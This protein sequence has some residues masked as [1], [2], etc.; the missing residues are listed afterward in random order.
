[1]NPVKPKKVLCKQNLTIGKSFYWDNTVK[2]AVRH[3]IDNRMLVKNFWYDTIENTNDSWNEESRNFTLTI[4]DN[5]NNPH[6]F[7]MYEPEDKTNWPDFCTHYGPRDY[8]KWFYTQEELEKLSEGKFKPQEDIYIETGNYHWVKPKGRDWEISLC[9]SKRQ[10]RG[11]FFWELIGSDKTYSDSDFDEIGQKVVSQE[12]S[13]KSTNQIQ[14][15]QELMDEIFPLIDAINKENPDSNYPPIEYVMPFVNKAV[16]K[17]FK[18]SYK[19]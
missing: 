5:Q 1:M 4:R 16:E 8:A 6:L 13:K 2:P 15:S 18:T 19:N 3:E 11:T 10:T 9:L 14:A 17:Y 12:N 7:Y